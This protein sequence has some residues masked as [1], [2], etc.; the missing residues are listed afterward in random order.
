MARSDNHGSHLAPNDPYN[1]MEGANYRPKFGSLHDNESNRPE[2]TNSKGESSSPN[3]SKDILRNAE[4]NALVGTNRQS[5]QSS[6]YSG[7]GRS[8][9]PVKVPGKKWKTTIA[10]FITSICLIAAGGAFLGSTHSL[11]G[12]ATV[13]HFTK[14]V[15]NTSWARNSSRRTNLVSD[16]SSGR[17]T[18]AALSKLT[19]IPKWL[20]NRLNTS[21]DFSVNGNSISYKGTDISGENFAQ[22]YKSNAELRSNFEDVA[23][24]RIIS[25]QDNTNTTMLKDNFGVTGNLYEN[26]KQTG[27]H[28]ANEAEYHKTMI[29]EFEGKTDTTLSTTTAERKPI[30]DEEGNETGEYEID[31]KQNTD[32]ARP[33]TKADSIRLANEFLQKL[34]A[35]TTKVVNY[36]C[37]ILRVGTMVA[38]A[39]SG[40]ATYTYAREFLDTMEP[41]SKMMAGEGSESPINAVLNRLTTPYTTEVEDLTDMHANLQLGAA[42]VDC[43]DDCNSNPELSYTPNTITYSGAAVESDNYRAVLTQ[44]VYN[45]Q[46]AARHSLMKS[47]EAVIKSLK[48]FNVTNAGCAILQAAVAGTELASSAL[49]VGLSL[50]PGGQIVGAGAVFWKV[51]RKHFLSL[52]T[53]VVMNFAVSS[54][55]AF[56]VPTLA[57]TLF[58]N[59]DQDTEGKPRGERL[60]ASAGV[61][62]SQ[63]NR[64][65]NGA[66]IVDKGTATAYSKLNQEVIAMEAEV[67]RLNRSP[68]DTSSSSTFLG[69]LAY[70]F[71]PLTLSSASI[72][73]AKTLLNTTSS[74]ISSLTQSVL[75]DGNTE[76]TTY[77]NTFGDCQ[78]LIDTYGEDVAADIYCN[79]ITIND[80]STLNTPVDDPNYQATI[81]NAI[82]G[83]D[84]DGNNCQIKA[85]SNLARYISYCADRSSPFGVVDANIL[86]ELENGNVIL[87][88]L[89]IVGDVIQI[90]DST[91]F[92]ENDEWATGKK[93]GSQTNPDWDTEY[94]Y[95]QLYLEDMRIAEQLGASVVTDEEAAWVNPVT[96]YREEYAKTHPKDDT[97]SGYIARVSGITKDD[98]EGLIALAEY[99]VLLAN[100]DPNERLFMDGQNTTIKS[101]AEIASEFHHRESPTSTPTTIAALPETQHVVYFDIRN[102]NYAV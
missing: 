78:T 90:L 24:G 20:S 41:P 89:P 52:L 81:S 53:G 99:Y 92:K 8:K 33:T 69:S 73:P 2:S 29:A 50:L 54:F 58:N 94:K 46:E 72:T 42:E 71:L 59:P 26:F 77:I 5:S 30:L 86:S 61:V 44:G 96:A 28:E 57:Q 45:K 40:I 36:G 85:D 100:Y 16:M 39:I 18:T 67:D 84:A 7:S 75:A 31:I 17:T 3:D 56:L 93:C 13:E 47:L 68:F 70:K 63:A 12:P 19:K 60:V 11:L 97:L 4:N 34:T 32:T 35:K 1:G 37:T 79:P 74:A 51:V 95:Y 80:P 87:N 101:S 66:N 83:C 102:R 27:N 15:V 88:A 9:V 91:H 48:V 65:N 62:S 76:N 38:T 64:R 22:M 25:M 10:A 98:A 43:K 23:Y 55:V 6:L 21:S 14:Q 82:E 49:A